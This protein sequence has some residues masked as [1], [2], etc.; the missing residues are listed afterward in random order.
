MTEDT[1]I[2]SESQSDFVSHA[3]FYHD[4][5]A[6]LVSGPETSRPDKSLFLH[7]A[8]VEPWEE[9][10]KVHADVAELRGTAPIA[11]AA[12]PWFE[13]RIEQSTS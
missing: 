3:T 7:A 10:W 9:A 12:P 13:N 6:L 5:E 11:H 2:F 1:S 8:G 4:V